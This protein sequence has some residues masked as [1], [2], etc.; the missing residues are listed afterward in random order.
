[1]SS[2][3][4]VVASTIFAASQDKKSH[5]LLSKRETM[6]QLRN[7]T[8]DWT[9][10][11]GGRAERLTMSLKN[12]IVGFVLVFVQAAAGCQSSAPLHP[13]PADGFFPLHTGSK[14][15]YGLTYENGTRGILS[16]R[17]ETS[18]GGAA[19]AV[20]RSDYTGFY[21]PVPDELREAYRSKDAEIKTRYNVD[22]GYLVRTESVGGVPGLYRFEESRF[23]PRDLRPGQ[24]WSNTLKPIAFLAIT[25]H[26]RSFLETHA[27]VVP[28][29]RFSGC[30]RVET[31]AFYAGPQGTTSQQYF[32][33]WYAPSVGL[34]KTLV[35]KR[36]YFTWYV[37]RPQLVS[38]LL[39]KSGLFSREVARVELLHFAGS[40]DASTHAKSATRKTSAPS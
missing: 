31:E 16:E 18:D 34:V 22:A 25:Q 8:A 17:V 28:A 26:H 23:L 29:G 21:D 11:S 10:A 40:S 7:C 4:S 6:R 3:G 33:D 39:S 5:C 19:A 35:L 9:K 1:M 24:A 12:W 36:G 30:I 37:A 15:T 38:A 13:T 20:V 27:V 2:R 32:I 14:W